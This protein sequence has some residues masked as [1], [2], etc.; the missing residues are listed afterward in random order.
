MQYF[1][2]FPVSASKISFACLTAGSGLSSKMAWARSVTPTARF[3]GEFC[4]VILL[5]RV[6][7]YF[8]RIL[9]AIDVTLGADAVQLCVEVAESARV[10]CG[11]LSV[12]VVVAVM[13]RGGITLGFSAV[14]SKVTCF[15]FV[16]SGRGLISCPYASKYSFLHYPVCSHVSVTRTPNLQRPSQCG[17][18]VISW[19]E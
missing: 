10:N 18:P 4:C 19:A 3:R 11:I 15:F 16:A 2:N 7:A 8:E 6:F 9:I 17:H 5:A 14:S 1:N 13:E 12:L